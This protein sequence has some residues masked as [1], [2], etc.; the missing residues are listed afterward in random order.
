MKATLK[1]LSS[2]YLNIKGNWSLKTL[3]F[4]HFKYMHT[5]LLHAEWA[6]NISIHAKVAHIESDH[7]AQMYMYKEYV[8]GCCT[9]KQRIQII[10]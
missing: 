10:F 2:A 9:Y 3:E 5:G 4:K 8:G 7:Y 1:L 6:G